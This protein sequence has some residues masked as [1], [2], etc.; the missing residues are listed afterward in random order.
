MLILCNGEARGGI[1]AGIETLK[2]G[3]SAL[4]V[5]EQAIRPVERDIAI[6]SVGRG[7]HPNLLGEVE[8][9]ASIMDGVTRESGAVGALRGYLHAISVARAVMHELPHV[10]L[11]GAGATR[12]AREIDAT[13]AEMLTIE[14][15]AWYEAWLARHA[16]GGPGSMARPS[17]RNAE[18]PTADAPLAELAWSAAQTVV[19][20]GTAVVLTIDAQ[21]RIAAGASSSGFRYKYPGRLGDSAVIGAGVYADQRYGACACTH[22]GEM[23]IRAGTARAVVLAMRR[24]ATV[25]EAS[26]EAIADL[27]ALTGGLLGAVVVHAID[28]HGNP[29]VVSTQGPQPEMTWCEWR[30]GMAGPGVRPARPAP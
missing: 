4:D 12:F 1:D 27:R 16:M 9:D 11:T 3:G 10:L 22:T 20:G 6:H 18:P 29:C 28:A 24:G 14:A 7:G 21:G 26:Q 15:R 30:A 17:G 19:S 13:P 5:V 2:R 23:T 8:C 25:E